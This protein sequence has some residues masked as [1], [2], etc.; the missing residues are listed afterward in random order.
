VQGCNYLAGLLLT[1][2]DEEDAFWVMVE[3]MNRFSFQGIFAKGFP[4]LTKTFFI[5][6]N[7]M[8]KHESELFNHFKNEKVESSLYATKWFLTL[9]AC[10]LPLQVV[11]RIWDWFFLKGWIF[12]IQTAL[13]V[14]H[15][16]KEELI[17]GDFA[18]IL[19]R[20]KRSEQFCN[21]AE[22]LIHL[23]KRYS[24]SDSEY[25]KYK[26]EYELTYN[27]FLRD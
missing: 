19:Q 23:A 9:F 26:R 10:T 4:F 2:M 3:M 6:E 24:I 13:G 11:Q 17:N 7:C 12:A 20:L 14:L 5:F 27:T 25:A 16:L 21:D 1:V 8:R 22:L 15:L 18:E